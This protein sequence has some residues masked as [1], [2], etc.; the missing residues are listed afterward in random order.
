VN[1]EI[2]GVPGA[3]PLLPGSTAKGV[4]IGLVDP[5]QNTPLVI[6]RTLPTPYSG[7][8]GSYSIPL[9]ATYLQTDPTIGGG[10]VN[11]AANVLIDYQ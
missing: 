2:A 6:N 7:Q 9:I 4:A 5:A 11:A 10:S 3:L 1:G 8:A